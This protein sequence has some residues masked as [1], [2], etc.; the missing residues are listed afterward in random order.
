[1]HYTCASCRKLLLIVL[2]MTFAVLFDDTRPTSY[3]AFFYKSPSLS[4]PNIADEAW[5]SQWHFLRGSYSSLEMI[6]N[7]MMLFPVCHSWPQLYGCQGMKIKRKCYSFKATVSR[8]DRHLFW[9]P[10]W[11][12][13]VAMSIATLAQTETC[14]LPFVVEYKRICNCN[15]IA[16]PFSVHILGDMVS[17]PLQVCNSLVSAL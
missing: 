3:T 14:C 2:D 15:L 11:H 16:I 4:H 5:Y 10:W 6:R 12:G 1:M 7:T 17:T 8:I 9:Y 13:N